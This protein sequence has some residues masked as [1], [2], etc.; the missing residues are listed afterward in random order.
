ML[1]LLI[2]WLMLS[3]VVLTGSASTP[4]AS[5]QT[6]DPVLVGAGDIANCS[7]EA[8]ERTAKLLD[9]IEGTVFTV[10]D[11]V[12][13]DGT[14]DE[15]AECYDPTWGRH[16]E[17]TRPAPGNHDYHTPGA[18]GYFAYFGDAAGHPGEGW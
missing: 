18:A 11:N 10:G 14:P 1:T 6:G 7:V 5:P 15:F 12:Y 17:R 8:D 4:V 3:L 13:P 2:S 9:E 16:K